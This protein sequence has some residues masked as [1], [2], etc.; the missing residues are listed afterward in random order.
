[1]PA[2]PFSTRS[3]TSKVSKSASRSQTSN[4]VEIQ[5]NSM[6]GAGS[7]GA[8]SSKSRSKSHSVEPEAFDV[9]RRLRNLTLQSDD[10]ASQGHSKLEPRA[11]LKQQAEPLQW[12]KEAGQLRPPA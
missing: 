6:S 4:S 8:G 12:E 1:M 9:T 7:A 2:L 5:H 10:V 3:S 11:Q